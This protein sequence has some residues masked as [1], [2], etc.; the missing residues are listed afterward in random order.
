MGEGPSMG[1]MG[2]QRSRHACRN[3]FC[4]VPPPP[5]LPT[6]STPE[7]IF[8]G[9]LRQ[10]TTEIGTNLAGLPPVY[11]LPPVWPG[12]V[13]SETA[14]SGTTAQRA[15]TAAT[16]KRSVLG[17]QSQLKTPEQA[18]SGAEPS[19]FIPFPSS[20]AVDVVGVGPRAVGDRFR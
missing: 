3:D 2:G 13:A 16:A 10:E 11:L 8:G 6:Q 19:S 18:C 17:S 5:T 4:K 15:R 14:N 7:A 12:C 1:A 9:I 20:S